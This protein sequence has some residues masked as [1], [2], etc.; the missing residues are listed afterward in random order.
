MKPRWSPVQRR[1]HERAS[2]KVEA[3]QSEVIS[4]QQPLQMLTLQL[5]ASAVPAPRQTPPAAARQQYRCDHCPPLLSPTV[6][7]RRKPEPSALLLHDNAI[8]RAKPEQSPSHK[9]QMLI[10]AQRWIHESLSHRGRK[11]VLP[12][13][14]GSVHPGYSACA[15]RRCANWRAQDH[16]EP[17]GKGYSRAVAP[18]HPRDNDECHRLNPVTSIEMELATAP[19]AEDR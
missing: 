5:Y 7:S 6:G 13:D 17:R 9:M 19:P 15:S 18:G 12:L 16:W 14:R 11:A 2:S 10:S 1:A 8:D 4:L 3:I